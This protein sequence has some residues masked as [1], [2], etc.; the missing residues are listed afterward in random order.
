MFR[1]TGII[2]GAAA[3]AALSLCAEHDRQPGGE[4]PLHNVMDV[5]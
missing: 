1:P 5:K 4:S 2:E 3:Q